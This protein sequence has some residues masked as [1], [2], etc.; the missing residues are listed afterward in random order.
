MPRCCS[1]SPADFQPS[2]A[3]ALVAGPSAGD[4]ERAVRAM[5]DDAPI[6]PCVT[7]WCPA[8][9]RVSCVT[10]TRGLFAAPSAYYAHC[11]V[12]HGRF[13]ETFQLTHARFKK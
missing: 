8:C 9:K 7:A 11:L 4:L 10:A 1:G 5:E 12:A 6:C 2:Y 13:Q 3:S